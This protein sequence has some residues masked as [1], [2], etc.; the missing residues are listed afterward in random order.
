MDIKEIFSKMK[1]GD[2]RAHSELGTRDESRQSKTF[3]ARVQKFKLATNVNARVL[4]IKDLVIPFNPFTGESDEEY[5]AKSK[6][7]PILLVSDAISLIKQ[8]CEANPDLNKFWLEHLRLS[9]WEHDSSETTLA[10][11][12]AFRD[13][14]YIKPRVMTYPTVTLK[15]EGRCGFPKFATKYTVDPDK[16]NPDYSYDPNNEPVEFLAASFF[17]SLLRPEVEAV[18]KKMEEQGANKDAIQKQRASIYSKSPVSFVKPTNIMP[19]FCFP[20]D[21]EVPTFDAK[22]PKSLEAYMRWYSFTDKWTIPLKEAMTKDMFDED[23]NFFDFTIKTPTSTDQ[24]GNG[25]VYTDDDNLEL[26]TAMTVTNTDGRLSF[27]SGQG[28][29]D[30]HSAPNS[31][32]YSVFNKLAREYFINSQEQSGVEGG[33]TFEYI[34][35]IS[36]RF[37]PITTVM[38]NFCEACNQVFA[39]TFADSPH[40]TDDFKKAHSKFF[41]MMNPQNALAMAGE[42]EEDLAAAAK[43]EASSV[44]ELLAGIRADEGAK[45]ADAEL[46]GVSPT[47]MSALELAD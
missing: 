17:Y 44:K 14:G 3:A 7:R 33:E 5:N 23:I 32:L 39:S 30:G 46:F 4:A 45:S 34:I 21:K 37:R 9:D 43:A 11:Y 38:D 6:F 27:V 8:A 16:L 40:C 22:D 2:M 26:Y 15:F 13:R 12:R 47:E 10:E 18:V 41:V 19:F 20:H 35:S 29:K 28:I 1:S 31:E 36:N 24:K 25:Q 42:D